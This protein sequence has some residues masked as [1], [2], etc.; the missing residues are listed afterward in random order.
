MKSRSEKDSNFLPLVCLNVCTLEL[1]F[2]YILKLYLKA[3]LFRPT[4][5]ASTLWRNLIG[6]AEEIVDVFRP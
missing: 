4:C 3:T 2:F 1:I 6:T 5:C